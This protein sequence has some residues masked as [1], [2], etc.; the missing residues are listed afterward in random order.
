[1]S[2]TSTVIVHAVKRWDSS[3]GDLVVLPTKRTAEWASRIGEI[4]EG[5]AESVDAS[6]VDDQGAYRPHK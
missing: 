5:T 6:L 4:I 2:N 1:M 3:K